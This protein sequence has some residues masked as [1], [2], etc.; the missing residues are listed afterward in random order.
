LGK[1]LDFVAA[2]KF[3]TMRM[4][5][6]RW[7]FSSSKTANFALTAIQRAP[8]AFFSLVFSGACRIFGE[9]LQEGTRIPFCSGY[10]RPRERRQRE[11]RARAF[12]SRRR[13][14]VT[15]QRFLLTDK[16]MTT[17]SSA[18]LTAVRVDRRLFSPF[19]PSTY[20]TPKGFPDVE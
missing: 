5:E 3:A 19:A 10:M 17:S 16:V 1:A 18:L 9:P 13:R 20:S 6:R 15:R 11:N 8:Y 12:R 2:E 4:F 7:V 14:L